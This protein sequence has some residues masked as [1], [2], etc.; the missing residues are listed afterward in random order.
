MVSLKPL[1]PGPPCVH[2]ERSRVS[3]LRTEAATEVATARAQQ[4]RMGLCM[5]QGCRVR[6]LG[7]LVAL[8]LGVCRAVGG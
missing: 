5:G 4:V 6:R 8:A 1:T 7:C 2:M 3:E